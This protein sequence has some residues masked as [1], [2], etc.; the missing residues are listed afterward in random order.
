MFT[1]YGAVPAAIDASFA[2]PV[3]NGAMVRIR[4]QDIKES[5][6]DLLLR[7]KL[8]SFHP[9]DDV[10]IQ[11][12]GPQRL[13]VNE[14]RVWRPWKASDHP[15]VIHYFR[16]SRPSGRIRHQHTGQQVLAFYRKSNQHEG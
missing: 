14:V 7:S 9:T 13:T 6:L 12:I 3:L 11:F 4:F 15:R 2:L 8:E 10:P 5:L 1:I 16:Q